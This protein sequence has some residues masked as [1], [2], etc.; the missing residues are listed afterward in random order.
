MYL[1]RNYEFHVVCV[2]TSDIFTRKAERMLQ[3]A[4]NQT[5]S[6]PNNSKM[7]LVREN[8]GK[9]AGSHVMQNLGLFDVKQK[10]LA[11]IS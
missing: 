3:Y 5:T 11:D 2:C 6:K 8:R 4:L 1:P 10:Y 7:K 9:W